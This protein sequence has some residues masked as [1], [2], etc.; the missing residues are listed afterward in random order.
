MTKQLKIYLSA[1]LE[2]LI[3]SYSQ[4]FFSKNKVFGTC[5]L[6]V[7]LFNIQAGLVGILC[8]LISQLLSFYLHNNTESIKSGLFSFNSLLVGIG[9][10]SIYE[11]NIS[12]I[13]LVTVAS[14]FSYL[15]CHWFSNSSSV[16]SV[17]FLSIPFLIVMWI[18]ILSSSKFSF[19]RFQQE[20]SNTLFDHFPV[21]FEQ[22]TNFILHLPFP[23][24]LLLYFRSLAAI[25]FQYNDLAGVVIAIGLLYFSRIASVM[26]FIG[27][28]IGYLFYY[29]FQGDFTDLIYSY[30][31]FNFILT[32]IALGGFYFVPSR[33]NLVL[34]ILSIPITALLVSSLTSLFIWLQLP[35]YSLPF[36]ITV[37]LLLSSISKSNYFNRFKLINFQSY[38]PETNYYKSQVLEKT[39]EDKSPIPI[40]LPILGIWRVSQGHNSKITHQENWK[41]AWDFDIVNEKDETFQG[42]GKELE[43]FLCYNMPIISP[44]D[45]YVVKIAN[46]YKD[47]KIGKVDLKNNWGNTMIIK[48]GEFLFS[49]L[50][51]LKKDSFKVA[52]GD[53][54]KKGTLIAKCGNSGRS[55]EPHLHFQLQ[56]SKYLGAS[57]I[58]YPIHLFENIIDEKSIT[59]SK[60]IPKESSKVKNTPIN[61][62]LKNAFTFMPGDI[63]NIK[64]NQTCQTWKV[65]VN[66]LNKSYMFCEKTNSYAYFNINNSAFE[67]FDFVGNE[68]SVLYS[69]YLAA[70][71][72]PF[73]SLPNQKEVNPI[74]VKSLMPRPIRL[75]QELL[76]PF[77]TFTSANHSVKSSL[78]NKNG[79]VTF[80]VSCKC[81][82]LNRI[83][84]ESNFKVS[85]NHDNIER[86]E[87]E[88]N[89]KKITACV[90]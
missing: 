90:N 38:S 17:P 14:I 89:D 77:Y 23:N 58:N 2:G 65:Y 69:F 73:Y 41:H 79:K 46:G 22:T 3:N 44:A 76:A 5:L 48:H 55:P 54:I 26:S 87:F 32:A 67:F 62:A 75:I 64:E 11:L 78:E 33:K 29:Q 56:A 24:F 85:V 88:L 74:P 49:K 86:F 15:I 59:N 39:K 40:Y 35:L 21:L 27:F 25:F 63:I 60:L 36:N 71:F 16:K 57:T 31:G 7:S 81:L 10:G 8:V 82:V 52:E 45:G 28:L 34:L 30:I 70:R 80:E 13:F 1:S 47:N 43:D 68:N 50:S 18:I 84:K 19:I 51:H 6:L 61:K 9:I 66:A 72:I 42:K 37:L 4:V 20:Y 83:F 53:F 12:S